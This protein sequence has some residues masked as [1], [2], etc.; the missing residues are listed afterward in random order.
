M[1]LKKAPSDCLYTGSKEEYKER[2]SLSQHSNWVL[3]KYKSEVLP[4]E[5]AY[6]AY[7]LL[8][9][10]LYSADISFF[11]TCKQTLLIVSL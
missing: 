10:L 3:P 1:H 6:S 2:Q 9:V 5:P 11:A 7:P 8:P 4:L